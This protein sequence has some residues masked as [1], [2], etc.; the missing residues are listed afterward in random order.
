MSDY[1]L[2]ANPTYSMKHLRH[3]SL[4]L[5]PTYRSN[6]LNLK[7]LV[8]IA[9]PANVIAIP[10][11]TCKLNTSP[12]MRYPQIKALTGTRNVTVEVAVAPALAS[13]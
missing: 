4:E 12:R 8:V 9:V 6:R 3:R 13:N 2:W 10:A 1:A 7:I 11:I 5:L